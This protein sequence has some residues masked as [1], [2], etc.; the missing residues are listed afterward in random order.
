MKFIFDHKLQFAGWCLIAL[1]FSVSFSSCRSTRSVASREIRSMSADRVIK[2]VEKESPRYDYYN[3][4]RISV[5]F[6][7]SGEKNSV[8]SQLKMRKDDRILV[9]LRKMGFPIGRGL[10]TNDSVKVVNFIERNFFIGDISSIQKLFGMDIDY[11]TIQ[12]LLTADVSHFV[13]KDLSDRDFTSKV[14]GQMYRLDSEFNRKISKAL[15]RGQEKLLSRY[16]ESMDEIEFFTITAWV[17]PE[18]FVVQK[19]EIK[20]IKSD[21]NIVVLY[22][23]YEYVNRQLFPTI[24]DVHYSEDEKDLKLQMKIGKISTKRDR[25]FSFTI[26]ERY[27]Q[28]FN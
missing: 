28:L 6:D 2:R 23:G 18:K 20:N 24:I 12:A 13:D 15:E 5:S 11:K 4:E 16:M 8:T 10:I 3:A 26:P 25:D 22:D 9:T 17:C 19:L 7:I 1:S 21:K 27:E 14:E